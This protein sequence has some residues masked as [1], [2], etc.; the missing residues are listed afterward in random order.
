MT[1]EEWLAQE[2]KE[3][4][5]FE[6]FKEL[7]EYRHHHRRTPIS[8]SFKEITMNAPLAGNTQ[9]Y[10]G[11]L[12]PVG[13]AFPAGTTFTVVASDSSATATVDS[14]GLVITV[15][16]GPSFVDNSASP[17][18][19]TWSTSVFAPAPA[20]SPSALSVTIT[21]AVAQ[22][23]GLTPTAVSFVQTA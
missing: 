9:V 6:E 20:T 2:L 22:T 21:P 18:S 8:I 17:F 14:T 3:F 15:A 1:H 11:T 23:A 16:Y 12:S 10:T 4:R 13:S 7:E 5:E 19:V